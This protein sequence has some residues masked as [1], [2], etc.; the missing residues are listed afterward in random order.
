VRTAA[1]HVELADDLEAVP[2]VEGHVGLG[3]GL[4]V[5]GLATIDGVVENVANQR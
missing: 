1:G 5:G 4:Q 2:L 3:L